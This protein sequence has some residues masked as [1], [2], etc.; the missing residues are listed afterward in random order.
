MLSRSPAHDGSRN[1]AHA[2]ARCGRLCRPTANN[3]YL[4]RMKK[5]PSLLRTVVLPLVLFGLFV[6]VMVWSPARVASMPL[7]LWSLGHGC[8]MASA[9]GAP[10]V[11]AD[12]LRRTAELSRR[13][14]LKTAEARLELWTIAGND[15]WAP[16]R[17]PLAFLIAEQQ[18]GT[19]DGAPISPGDTVLDCGANIGAYVR[20]AL[21]RGAARVIAI[22]P[23]PDNIEALRRN[24]DA[25]ILAGKVVVYPK[26]V[27]SEVSTLPM[28]VYDNAA[29]HSF[30]MEERWEAGR[31]V[32]TIQLPL[33]T[34]DSLVLEL[35]L[36]R[37]DVIKMDI[38]G[39]ER[40]AL[41]G[42]RET[43]RRFR[44]RLALAA[45][46]LDDDWKV[47]RDR[48]RSIEPSYSSQAGPC[49]LTSRPEIH[50]ESL[51]FTASR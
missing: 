6:G 19:Y 43:L 33:T 9:W 39:A 51:F 24:F 34:V 47:L 23:V 13:A 41:L 50:L 31:A 17:T 10:D 18:R 30:V 26:G 11:A 12:Q 2:G 21:D 46:N 48:V 25:E 36:D 28:N 16:P 38:E 3:W 14:H 22:E 27:W 37:V 29:F 8:A 4:P 1:L 45:E 35:G 5:P 44:P 15:W 7:M 49:M 40:E 20:H 32:R 42:A